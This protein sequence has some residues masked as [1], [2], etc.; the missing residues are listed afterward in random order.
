VSRPGTSVWGEILDLREIDVRCE[1]KPH[2]V[3]AVSVGQ[4]AH[5]QQ[6]GTDLRLSGRVVFVGPAADPQSGLVPVLVRLAN[7]QERL[8]CYVPVKVRFDK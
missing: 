5:V 7:P 4:K 8:R 1:L 2:Q 3:D 6:E